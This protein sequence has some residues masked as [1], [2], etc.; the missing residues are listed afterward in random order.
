MN[1][2]TIGFLKLPSGH[3]HAL[4]VHIQESEVATKINFLNLKEL[5]FSHEYILPKND[6]CLTHM[7]F[8]SR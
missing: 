8:G 3:G 5:S 1:Q 4:F 7:R 2:N 6:A